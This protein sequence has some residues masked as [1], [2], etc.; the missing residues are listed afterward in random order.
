MNIYEFRMKNVE[1]LILIMRGADEIDCR[2]S[3]SGRVKI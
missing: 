2:W 3:G 1:D